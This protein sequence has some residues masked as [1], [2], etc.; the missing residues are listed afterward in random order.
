[1]ANVGSVELSLSLNKTAFDKDLSSLSKLEIPPLNLDLKLDAKSLNKQLKDLKNGDYGCL[2]LEICPDIK[3]LSR[4]LKEL[5]KSL[6]DCIPVQICPDIKG[7]EAK[8]AKLANSPKKY[9]FKIDADKLTLDV[10]EG[11][12]RGTTRAKKKLDIDIYGASRGRESGLRQ[13]NFNDALAPLKSLSKDLS[14]TF[15]SLADGL[16]EALKGTVKAVTSNNPLKGLA[17]VFI[18]TIGTIGSILAPLIVLPLKVLGSSLGSVAS[19]IGLQIGSNL[20]QSLLKGAIDAIEGSLSKSIG[21]FSLLGEVLGKEL[22]ALIN[23][24]GGSKNPLTKVLASL[25]PTPEALGEIV[26]ASAGKKAIAIESNAKRSQT[27]AANKAKAEAAREEALTAY[28][29]VKPRQA[30]AVEIA[31]NLE[32]QRKVTDAK[33]TLFARDFNA[34]QQEVREKAERINVKL[35]PESLAKIRQKEYDKQVAQYTKAAEEL[36]KQGATRDAIKVRQL[37]ASLYKP[38]T[39]DITPSEIALAE[40]ER[41]VQARN[42]FTS[43]ILN[44]EFSSR[45]TELKS[46]QRKLAELGKQYKTE[47]EPVLNAFTDIEALGLGGQVSSSRARKSARGRDRTALTNYEQIAQQVAGLSGTTLDKTQLPKLAISAN[48]PQGVQAAYSADKNTVLVSEALKDQVEQGKLTDK[49]LELLIHELRH[50]VQSGFGGSAPLIPDNQLLAPT[51]SEAALLGRN[52]ERSVSIQ[53]PDKQDSYRRTE[54][55]AYVFAR[56][57]IATVKEEQAKSQALANLNKVSGI[58]GSKVADFVQG[59]QVAA[60][61]KVQEISVLGKEKGL[62]TTK[63][64]QQALAD[65]SKIDS[66]LEKFLGKIASAESLSVSEIA[67]LEAELLAYLKTTA[68]QINSIPTKAIETVKQKLKAPDPKIDSAVNKQ[69]IDTKEN[70]SRLT[71]E[72]LRSIAKKAQVSTYNKETKK[73]STKTEL[74]DVLSQV[75]PTILEPLIPNVGKPTAEGLARSKTLANSNK[76]DALKQVKAFNAKI[77]NKTKNDR[78]LSQRQEALNEVITELAAVESAIALSSDQEVKRALKGQA[79]YLSRL[80]LKIKGA[81]SEVKLKSR[82]SSITPDAQAARELDDIEAGFGDLRE[83]LENLKRSFATPKTGQD[84]PEMSGKQVQELR[85]KQLKSEREDRANSFTAQLKRQAAEDA[86]AN[87]AMRRIRR[88]L[89]RPIDIPIVEPIKTISQLEAEQQLRI[90]KGRRTGLNDPNPN[91]IRT[92]LRDI[93]GILTER[94]R[95]AQITKA[96]YLTENASQLASLAAIKTGDNPTAKQITEIQKLQVAFLNLGNAAAKYG[97]KNSKRNFQELTKAT[98]E[99]EASLSKLGVPLTRIN[100]LVAEQS[101]RLSD[102]TQSGVDVP[103][104]VAKPFDSVTESLGRASGAG[105][106]LLGVTGGLLRGF[107]AFSGIAFLQNVFQGIATSSFKAFVEIDRLKT[108]LNFASGS[109]IQGSQNLAFIKQQVED[110]KI[111]LTSAQQGFTQLAAATRGGALEGRPTKDIFT[112]ITAASTVLSLSAEDTQGAFL[113]LSQIAS[114]GKVQAEELRGQLGERIPGAFAIA[115]RSM[116]VTEAELNKLLETG[117]VLAQDF[118]PRFGQQLQIEFGDAAADASGNAQSAIFN[119]QNTFLSLQQTIGETIGPVVVT[120]FN[121]FA[122]ALKGI[123]SV[124]DE[125]AIAVGALSVA[126]LVNLGRSLKATIAN[127]IL[128]KAAGGTLA[129]AFSSVAQSINN[130]FSA[131]LTVGIFAVVEIVKLLADTVNTELVKSF[132]SAAKSATRAAEQSAKALEKRSNTTGPSNDEEPP[133]INFVDT[134]TRGISKANPLVKGLFGGGATALGELLNRGVN[135]AKTGKADFYSYGDLQRDNLDASLGSV[136]SGANALIASGQ[137]NLSN[138]KKS[139]SPEI[140]NQLRTLEDLRRLIQSSAERDFS[141]KGLAVPPEVKKDLED[142]TKKIQTLN[143][144]RSDLVK[145]VTQDLARIARQISDTKALLKQLDDPNVVDALGTEKAEAR[146][147]QLLATIESLKKFQ[148]TAEKALISLK[149]DPVLAFT[150]AIRKLNVELAKNIEASSK[151]FLSKKES[152]ALTS[153][154]DFSTNPNASSAEALRNAIDERDARASEADALNRDAA[155]KK[156]ALATPEFTNTLSRFGLTSSSS[157][158]EVQGAIDRPGVD[159]ADKAVL[160]NIKSVQEA[161]IKASESR[162][163]RAEAEARLRKQIEANALNFIAKRADEYEAI[164]RRSE[165]NRTAEVKKQLS[166]RTITEEAGA[167]AIAKKQYESAYA[168]QIYLKVELDNLRSFYQA[169][170]ISAETFTTKERELVTRQAELKQQFEESGLALREANAKRI[171]ADLAE[172]NSAFESK[173]TLLQTQRNTAIKQSQLNGTSTDQAGRD[174]TDSDRQAIIDRIKLI[175]DE[176]Y[177]NEYSVKN[178]IIDQRNFAK[179]QRRLNQELAVANDNLAANDLQREKEY[180]EEFDKIFSRERRNVDLNSANSSNAIARDAFNAT[181]NA[182]TPFDTK[183]FD[184]TTGRSE[185]E[186]RNSALLDQLNILDQQIER[187]PD[188]RLSEEEAAD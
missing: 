73:A 84:L 48:L 31:K 61:K 174:T 70:L 106:K 175:K 127:L 50:A 26:S 132:D 66:Q 4:K 146:R 49:N 16:L 173:I 62:D 148:S 134:L 101:D 111:P 76:I 166:D 71:V 100:Q 14:N 38:N 105:G 92:R 94:G 177:Q 60:L 90:S 176:Q 119:L 120:A 42:R 179:E 69:T 65:I 52:I 172:I 35:T 155:A 102:L 183:A 74:I 154:G 57:N 10:E 117:Q 184:L 109:S 116:G 123:G 151:A 147:E 44:K 87:R 104:L 91:A 143:E 115:A 133:E 112:G 40:R 8:L 67:K 78:P 72:N 162:I 121:G 54:A 24:L 18:K 141:L 58:G 22:T 137:L 144:Q 97:E 63:L 152:S 7:F 93:P 165:A 170:Y 129:G 64:E 81:I 34:R 23:N 11:I 53:A 32:K 79:L 153:L 75:S 140:E 149:A 43:R 150:D 136:N 163:A 28:E 15:K 110:F 88:E 169:G 30:E 160:E 180:R 51:A 138:F 139:R 187:I 168:R 178:K 135:F 55:D 157:I 142:V 12:N 164:T 5:P 68:E 41:T 59:R 108:A 113:A 98:A 185:L 39:K 186:N 159:E 3:G 9:N 171:L 37:I 118:L 158:A 25:L 99:L 13:T 114:K 45:R 2:E 83:E 17:T 182:K 124:I 167:E 33:A 107:L 103:E 1:M 95:N 89:K 130:S 21:S 80:R 156:A 20:S 82:S 85:A 46:E 181:V 122:V 126:L 77:A 188:L 161:E 131:K 47:A 125:I 29:A 128:T 86:N 27:R 36:Q 19:G 96:R 6:V 56:R 145:P